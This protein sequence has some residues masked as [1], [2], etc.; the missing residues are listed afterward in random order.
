[1]LREFSPKQRWLV[2]VISLPAIFIS[3]LSS[4]AFPDAEKYRLSFWLVDTIVFVVLPLATVLLIYVVAKIEPKDYGLTQLSRNTTEGAALFKTCVCIFIF[5]LFTPLTNFF[6]I[7]FPPT[8][9]T[10]ESYFSLM[11]SGQF[12]FIARLYLSLSAAFAE[13][14]IFRGVLALVLVGKDCSDK[15]LYVIGSSLLFALGHFNQGLHVVFAAAVLGVMA[16][17]IYLKIKN[18]WYLI[19]GHFVIGLVSY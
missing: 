18:L 19:L 8:T 2:F 9:N 6:G 15:Y 7:F 5:L 13:E 1:M 3:F 17:I 4:L 16:A 14:I 12:G 11:L 10:E